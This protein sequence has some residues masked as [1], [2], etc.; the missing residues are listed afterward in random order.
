GTEASLLMLYHLAADQSE[1]TQAML[2][3]LVIILDPMLNPDGRDRFVNWV[4]GYRSSVPN[5]DIQDLE[6]NQPWPRGRTNH[7]LHDLNRDWLLA[8]HPES[9]ARLE[10]FHSWRP[11]LLIDAHEMGRNATYFF[12]PGIPERNN[13]NTPNRTF[14]I[15]WDIAQFHATFLDKVGALYFTKESF[16]DFYYGKGSTYPDINGAIGILFEQASS[17]A[18]TTESDFGELTFSKTIQQQFATS[19]STITSAYNLRIDLLSHQKEFYQSKDSFVKSEPVK[20]Y[21]INILDHPTRVNIFLKT[22]RYHRIK[23]HELNQTVLIDG[24]TFNRDNALILPLHQPQARLIKSIMETST[25]FQ[26]SIFYDVSTWTFPLAFGIDVKEITRNPSRWIGDEISSLPE[27]QTAI[28][29]QANYAY[30][31]EWDRFN[32][33]NALY[34]ILDAGLT[35]LVATKPISIEI[36]SG[37]LKSFNRGSII[38]PVHP[39]D[40]E[41]KL[42]SND[43]YEL[44]NQLSVQLNV[45]IYP[46]NT[47][48]SANGPSLGSP[49]VNPLSK[50][51]V[52]LLAGPGTSSNSVGE[53]WF[54]LNTKINMP[55]S[56]VN[57]EDISY[58]DLSR[59]TTM[60]MPHGWYT[61]LDS[62]ALNKI[63]FWVKKGG[64]LIAIEGGV[65]TLLKNDFISEEIIESPK[66]T[67]QV[68]YDQL[69][70]RQ[71]AQEIGGAIFKTSVDTSHPLAFGLNPE[72]SV[73]R[74]T[75]LFLKPSKNQTAN[76]VQYTEN[77]LISGYI[78]EG[79]LKLLAGSSAVI[80]R[81]MG[82]GHVVLL[83]DDPYFRSFWYGTSL[84]LMNGIFFGS[85][86]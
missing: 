12:Q 43:I 21:I 2:D 7:Y 55:V 11:Q 63:K 77:P 69:D 48:L 72:L 45:N 82:N 37:E 25:E 22:M 57:V 52:C 74:K 49:H 83:A 58:K 27:I 29:T 38:I 53:I 34:Q 40:D 9:E 19:M 47:G 32:A 79:N 59:Y 75:G 84:L 50:P 5:T 73:F 10:L 62:V 13:P 86:Y 33:P 24:H 54:L 39:R 8:Q 20:A 66:D 30:I 26:A 70:K 76:V 42:S 61:S 17:R 3:N 15:T 65:N 85:I 16:D 81:K 60:I 4:N 56:L 23:V 6:H 18:M 71:G 64:T 35:P 44:V 68:A 46:L 14:D 80:G 41:N 78:S 51:T 31:M 1:E 28:P 67:V 36:N